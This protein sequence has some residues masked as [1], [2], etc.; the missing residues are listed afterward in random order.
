LLKT[1]VCSGLL[2]ILSL[3]TVHAQTDAIRLNKFAFDTS[4]LEL[5]RAAG[6][7]FFDVVG[8][9][10]AVFGIENSG[11]E[12]WVYP[13]K[14]LEDVH[15]S[16][17]L[18][19]DTRGFSDTEL[20]RK[21]TVRPEATT[22]TYSH[23][24]FTVQAH[25]V[26]PLDKPGVI[27]LLDIDSVLPLTVHVS[28][29]PSLK[30]MWPAGSATPF[31]TWDTHQNVYVIG[32]DSQHFAAMIGSP[33]ARQNSQQRYQEAPHELRNEFVIETVPDQ[34]RHQ[35]IPVVIAGAT[36][37][38][39]QEALHVYQDLLANAALYV[40]E[41]A[42]Y[43]KRLLESTLSVKTPDDRLNTAFEWAKIGID[44][45][46]AT[47]PFLG[48]GLLAGFQTSGASE[49]PGFA[50]F[51]GRDS[52]WT[53]LAINSY[54]DFGKTRD[55]LRL[56][57]KYQRLDGK[58]MHE[59]SQSATLVDWFKGFPYAYASADSSPLYIIAVADY[60]SASADQAF[61]R[62]MWES[63]KQAY[64]FAAST[65]T[66]GDGLIENT[67]VGHGWV[68]GGTLYPEHEEIYLAGLW[69]EACQAISSLAATM[70]DQKLQAQ[71][72]AAAQKA[73]EQLEKLFWQE[74][75]GIYAFA[76]KQDRSVV[77]DATV[78]PTVPMWWRLLDENHAAKMLEKVASSNLSTD[79]GT[80]ILSN[81]S[82]KYD[83][84]SYHNGSVW[85][86]FTGWASLG[87]YCYGKPH[88]GYSALKANA[89]LTYQDALGYVTEV[90]SGDFNQSFGRSTQ[91]QVWSSAMVVTPL[92][93]GLLGLA[94]DAPSRRVGFAP[95][96]PADWD[97]VE[98]NN[99]HLGDD[100]FDFKLK[101][102]TNL[103]SIEINRR[104]SDTPIDVD[105]APAFPVDAEILK[106]SVD[107]KPTKLTVKPLGDFN[108]AQV[109]TTVTKHALVE[110]NYQP[111]TEVVPPIVSPEI[112]ARTRGLKVL[113]TT[114]R[115]GRFLLD[116]EGLAGET[117][118]IDIISPRQVLKVE[119]ASVVADGRHMK[120]R[121]APQKGA[122]SSEDIYVRKVI[123][124][125]LARPA[126]KAQDK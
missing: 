86:L 15:L 9:R 120:L 49:R 103:M 111:G 1:T 85:P 6:P 99:F 48:S 107:G 47:N 13:L 52:E 21:I 98:I 72:V 3:T 31:V 28:F 40:R 121:Y 117:Y 57:K 125:E 126:V 39:A 33:Q 7:E 22:F 74:Q 76:I 93:R 75:S 2:C 115:N 91:H 51:F 87:A 104:G 43:Y 119:N 64:Q 106:A 69:A 23:A 101:R 65:D 89:E 118:D 114:W 24:A 77:D 70:N 122:N 105:L 27:I 61:L 100:T 94:A 30:S 54:G 46:F 37:Q 45:G 83:P 95:Q 59:L 68:E 102:G 67:K 42:A 8:R 66:D 14:L 38:G 56:L 73:R 5:S 53:S 12:A 79:W 112:G 62:E 18:Q 29:K 26:A 109:R 20:V 82:P 116:V 25:F 108:Q 19:G 50:W 88:L 36:S 63:V 123:S 60:Y 55:A 32:E 44:K 35:F 71:S 78:M 4:G 58:I 113:S 92:V 90:L 10:S 84:L 16:F 124:V 80:R 110:I 96:L 81:R 97:Q 34:S 11:F 41:N 17:Q